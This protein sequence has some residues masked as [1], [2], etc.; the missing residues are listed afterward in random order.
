MS[1]PIYKRYRFRKVKSTTIKLRLADKSYI[2]PRGEL[3]NV[4]VK[5]NKFILST[6]FVAL[7]MVEDKDVPM[8]MGTP[9]LATSCT[10]INVA[11]GALIMRVYNESMVIKVIELS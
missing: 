2:F 11:A 8:I 5:V 4:F 1:F 9:F 6:N 7:D 10:I 3:V